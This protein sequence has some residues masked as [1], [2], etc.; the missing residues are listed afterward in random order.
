VALPQKVRAWATGFWVGVLFLLTQFSASVVFRLSYG[1]YKLLFISAIGIPA[2]W[3][4]QATGFNTYTGFF[5]GKV[6]YTLLILG[7]MAAALYSYARNKREFQLCMG[8]VGIALACVVVSN[9]ASKVLHSFW[10]QTFSRDML[11]VLTSPFPVLFLIPVVILYR[12]TTQRPVAP[13]GN[14]QK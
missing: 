10:L 1:A 12:N 6:F 13:R 4:A 5:W 14:V 2:K 3:V 9:V 11:E 8:L 7:S